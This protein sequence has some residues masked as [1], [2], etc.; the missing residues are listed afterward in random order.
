MRLEFECIKPDIKVGN[1]ERNVI[2]NEVAGI[3]VSEFDGPVLL[4]HLLK[5]A[6]VLIF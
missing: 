5:N 6:D 3:E 2:E 1:W 4:D